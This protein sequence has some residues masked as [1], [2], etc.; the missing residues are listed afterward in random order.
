MRRA[1][2]SLFAS[3]LLVVCASDDLESQAA[4]FLVACMEEDG[5]APVTDVDFTIVE[6][7]VLVDFDSTYPGQGGI[8]ADN[9]HNACIRE[10]VT[11]LDLN[12]D[13]P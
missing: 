13:L 6:D 2:L 5:V 11:E 12:A 9:V 1:A 10:L 4:T 3:I 8:D 7:R